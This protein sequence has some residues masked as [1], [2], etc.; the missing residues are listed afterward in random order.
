MRVAVYRTGHPIC[1]R[2]AESLARGLNG[3]LHL[4]SDGIVDADVHIA[5]GILRGTSE[6]FK[7]A[8]KSG[9][10][11]FVVDRGFWGAE[12]YDGLYR[13]AYRGT[14][15]IYRLFSIQKEHS[16]EVEPYVQREGYTLICPPSEYVCDWFGIKMYPARLIETNWELDWTEKL[17]QSNQRIQVRKKSAQS[18]IDWKNVASLVTYNSSVAIEAIK[19]GIPVISDKTN[20]A[21][22]SFQ[23]V[24]GQIHLDTSRRDSLLR[25]LSA[26]QM[27][28]C[29]IERGRAWEV[30]HHYLP[31][32]SAQ[33]QEK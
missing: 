19:R 17:M 1:D 13:I 29:D 24:V 30:I 16:L 7:A 26:H 11:W 14:Q 33:I 5:Y 32:S 20:S 28:L 31:Y 18:P 10:P 27:S 3:T 4:A 22:G 25:W 23:D 9:K 21:V 2:V 15:P 12:H 8:E 6:V